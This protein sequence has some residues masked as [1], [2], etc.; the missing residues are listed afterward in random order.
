MSDSPRKIVIV[1]AG[2]IGLTIAHLLTAETSKTS[3]WEVSIV[4]R[5]M[6]GDVDS[7]GWA[8]PWAVRSHLYSQVRDSQCVGMVGRELVTYWWL[9]QARTRLGEG[10]LVSRP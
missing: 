1:G 9:R 4:A 6:P 2:V 3:G 8:S 7:T 5:D 10:D